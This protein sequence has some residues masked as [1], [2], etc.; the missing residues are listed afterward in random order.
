MRRITGGVFLSLDG[1][2]QAPGGPSEDWTGGFTLGGWL[3]AFFDE[4]A[5]AT[6]GKLF[7]PP[8]ALLLG[9]STYDIFA[10]Y[11]PYIQGEEAAMGEAITRADKYVLTHRDDL[12]DWE[13][14]HSLANIEAV[15]ALKATD[16]PDLLIQGSSTIYPALLQAGL[17]DRLT[18]LT[19]PL[20]LGKGKRLFGDG[21]PPG[22]LTLVEHE[23]SSKGVVIASYEPAG[24][25][26]TASFGMPDKT[27]EREKQR[28]RRMADQG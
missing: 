8:Y 11:W 7:T 25:V 2:M 5:G 16:G 19:F 4:A 9:R 17:I 23:V 3:P 12:P 24:T 21:T 26:E 13:N 18:T 6:V 27:S 10:A 28:Q 1:V 15:A 14:S 20:L 22:T